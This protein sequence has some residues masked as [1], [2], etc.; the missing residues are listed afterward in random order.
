MIECPSE[1]WNSEVMVLALARYL[2]QE[3]VAAV[4]WC[5][6]V[7]KVAPAALGPQRSGTLGAGL[8]PALAT[9]H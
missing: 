7:A 6:C 9:S 5:L 8:E 4:V 3:L 2:G 1:S